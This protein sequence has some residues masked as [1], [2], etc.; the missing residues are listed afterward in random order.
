MEGGKVLTVPHPR[1]GHQECHPECLQGLAQ[2]DGLAKVSKTGTG[3]KTGL[4]GPRDCLSY[5]DPLV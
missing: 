5:G 4:I 3:I 1:I 2:E